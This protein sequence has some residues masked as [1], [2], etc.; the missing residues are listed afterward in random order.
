MLETAGGG[1]HR[2]TPC[3]L[4]RNVARAHIAADHADSGRGRVGPASKPWISE[5]VRDNH[6]QHRIPADEI[7][8]AT[9]EERDKIEADYPLGIADPSCRS[10]S[11]SPKRRWPKATGSP[12]AHPCWSAWPRCIRPRRWN[13][14]WA[15]CCTEC[16]SSGIPA[17]NRSYAFVVSRSFTRKPPAPGCGGERWLR[18]ARGQ[19]IR[20]HRQTRQARLDLEGHAGGGA[21]RFGRWRSR[22]P[23]P[24]SSVPQTIPRQV[25]WDSALN[26]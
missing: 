6:H 18:A 5:R 19:R 9:G 20:N 14:C 16:P 26:T 17:L 4:T 2:P 11:S 25:T 24:I 7:V 12:L 1:R 3:K 21:W 13:R 23:K 22:C 8:V 15:G 10:S